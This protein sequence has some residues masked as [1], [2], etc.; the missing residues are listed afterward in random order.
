MNAHQSLR[1]LKKNSP[2][3]LEKLDAWSRKYTLPQI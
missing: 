2:G 1:S 3:Y